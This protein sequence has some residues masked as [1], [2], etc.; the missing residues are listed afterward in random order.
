MVVNS[1]QAQRMR[2]GVSSSHD[3]LDMIATMISDA[4]LG[5]GGAAN[6]LINEVD[7]IAKNLEHGAEIP[8]G[9]SSVVQKLEML[10]VSLA[11]YKEQYILKYNLQEYG[12]MGREYEEI[13]NNFTTYL[14]RLTASKIL[15]NTN[16]DIGSE[17]GELTLF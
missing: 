13:L 1:K 7:A 8:I 10:H 17:A 5:L 2:E 14:E 12:D 15:S 16:I 3:E 6:R 11:D 9:L 4:V